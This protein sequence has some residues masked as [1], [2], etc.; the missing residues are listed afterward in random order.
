MTSKRE[1]VIAAVAALIARALPNAEVRRNLAKA[2]RLGPGGL[3]V[4]RDGDPGEPEAT[5][6]PL[7]YLYTHSIPVEIAACESVSL[8]RETV[9]DAMLC[10]IGAAVTSNRTLGGLCDWIEA[11]APL[12]DDVETLGALPGR[13][14]QL[15]IVAVYATPDP[16][17]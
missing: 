12:T 7:S 9:L 6:S 17:N 8:P 16:L 1:S 13:V 14:A 4:I 5:L 11:E 10:A 15:T 3:V 2:E